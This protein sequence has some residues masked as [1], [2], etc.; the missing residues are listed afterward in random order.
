MTKR[1]ATSQRR[2]AVPTPPKKT[3]PVERLFYTRQ[4]AAEVLRISLK[5]LDQIIN[6]KLVRAIRLGRRRILIPAQELE[7]IAGGA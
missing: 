7:R 1:K 6:R 4:E 3:L 5:T 2:A